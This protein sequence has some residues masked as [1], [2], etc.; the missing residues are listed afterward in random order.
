MYQ[1][2]ETSDPVRI[3]RDF[4]SRELLL[5]LS[6]KPGQRV[7]SALFSVGTTHPCSLLQKKSP[8]SLGSKPWSNCNGA[9]TAVVLCSQEISYAKKNASTTTDNET[10][11]SGLRLQVFDASSVDTRNVDIFWTIAKYAQDS[12]EGK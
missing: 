5:H 8:N 7:V 11:P 4:L 6:V 10:S 2:L 9:E 1:N 12:S 3:S